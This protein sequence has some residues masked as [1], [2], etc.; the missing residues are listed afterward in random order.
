MEKKNISSLDILASAYFNEENKKIRPQKFR[1]LRIILLTS[2]FVFGIFLTIMKA[3]PTGTFGFIFQTTKLDGV[4]KTDRIKLEAKA[5]TVNAYFLATNINSY[6]DDANATTTTQNSPQ[7]LF[8]ASAWD[9]VSAALFRSMKIYNAATSSGA[10][11]TYE[12]RI[13]DNSGANLLTLKS[14]G[15]LQLK[16]G[17]ALISNVQDPASAQ[18]AAT[19]NY[20]DTCLASGTCAA[21]GSGGWIHNTTTTHLIYPHATTDLVLVGTATELSTGYYLQLAGTSSLFAQGNVTIAPSGSGVTSA[22]IKGTSGGGTADIFQVQDA[23]G[24]ANYLK[25][26]SAGDATIG[27]TTSRN[28]TINGTLTINSPNGTLVIQ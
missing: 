27:D 17:N 2:L 26:S 8:T 20:V 4:T 14:S 25:I 28:Q 16:T 10:S 22:T 21:G 1:A 18:D 9:G 24:T 5:D 23:A 12:L 15:V 11:P 19:K 13:D 7:H 3:P 6:A